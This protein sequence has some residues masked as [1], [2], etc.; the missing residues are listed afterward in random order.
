MTK[1]RATKRIAVLV[2]T[3]TGW[4]RN[5]ICG[6]DRFGRESGDWELEV[7]PYAQVDYM[8]LP[9]HWKGDG[10][11]A[12]VAGERMARELIE[13]GLPVVNVSSIP[14]QGI[15]FPRVI[16]NF[17]NLGRL[18]ATHFMERGFFNFAYCGPEDGPHS[19]FLLQ[20]GYADA[21]ADKGYSCRVMQ[22]PGKR[23]S[24]GRRQEMLL[25]L[26]REQDRPLAVFAWS[27][28]APREIISACRQ[29][30]IS[31]PEEVAVAS[32]ASMDELILQVMY[33]SISCVVTPETSIGYAAA[34]LLRNIM[35]ARNFV[36]PD[37]TLRIEPSHVEVRESSD[38][39]AVHDP[40]VV[41]AL[42]YMK[43]HAVAGI[44]VEEVARH[45]GLSR[46]ALEQKM[47]H[48]L[49]RTPAEEIRLIRLNQAKYL[50]QSTMLS[51]PDVSEKSGFGT[52]EHFITY[53]RKTT[54]IT[55]LQYA[56]KNR[57]V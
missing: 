25:K 45:A 51:I 1:R 20:T 19:S 41:K 2:D 4:G 7:Q 46:R 28:D 12:R 16:A 48:F 56:K 5:I 22:M 36:Q 39:L 31:V 53:F 57:T 29:G 37:W 50:L 30:G 11:I 40:G 26:I 21:L 33:P 27:I 54:G 35:R 32:S 24:P 43:N 44:S 13:T 55:P 18:A 34:E 17:E 6:V 14:L 10:V 9:P 49:Q 42:S 15:R 52:V 8:P 23:I 47:K 38:V 3:S